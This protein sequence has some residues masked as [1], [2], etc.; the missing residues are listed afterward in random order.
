MV[1]PTTD[2]I[3]LILMKNDPACMRLWVQTP[4]GFARRYEVDKDMSMK[5]IGGSA[6]F[7]LLMIYFA[8]AFTIMSL[9]VLLIILVPLSMVGL[10]G[11]ARTDQT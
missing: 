1:A 8:P 10:A 3:E 6:L 5:I 11:Y 7:L 2:R 9:L 4:A